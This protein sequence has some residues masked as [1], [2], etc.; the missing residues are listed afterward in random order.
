MPALFAIL[1]LLV[2]YAANTGD[3]FSQG[4]DFLFTPDF[5]KLTTDSILIA[6]G[7]AFFTLSLGMGAI[8]VYGS[9]LSKSA[10]IAKVSL[11]IAIADT[12]VALLAGMAIFPIVFA[13][14][15]S[16]DAGF[17]LIFITLPISFGHMA[18]GTL[19]GGIFFLLLVFAAWTSAISLIEPA[20]AWLVENKQISRRRASV[21]VG[22]ATWLLGLLT[23][24]SFNIGENWLLFGMTMFGLLDYLTTNIMLPLGGLFIAIFSG[25]IISKQSSKEELAI[26]SPLNYKVWRALIRYVSPIAIII[27]F[28]NII[29]LLG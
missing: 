12:L 14:G 5:S 1:V 27:V 8:M 28:L 11:T 13:N 21:T 9:Y 17:G 7:H 26:K 18:G 2:G 6:M 22:F 16:P 15:L 4:I 23:V 29:G 20:V 19:F 25:W 3:Y 24:F 10:P